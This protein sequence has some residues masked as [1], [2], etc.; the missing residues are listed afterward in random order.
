MHE[1]KRAKAAISL[2]S[3]VFTGEQKHRGRR[4]KYD[5]KVDLTDVSRFTWVQ[6]LEAN[7]KLYTAVVWHMSLKR[8]IRIAYISD[9][10]IPGK[11]GYVL[12]FSTDLH[13]S[14]YDIYCFYK[15]RF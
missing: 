7:L 1:E 11:V 12:F 9:T 15:A 5:G 8:Q 3:I 13:L 10:R 14:A 4:R 6:D 2:A